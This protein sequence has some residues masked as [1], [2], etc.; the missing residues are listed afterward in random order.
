MSIYSHSELVERLESA[1]YTAIAANTRCR[2]L[3]DALARKDLEI[4]NL[5]YAL[6][7]AYENLASAVSCIQQKDNELSGNFCPYTGLLVNV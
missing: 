6:D 1:Q 7:I 5:Q 2:E 4:A 3:Q